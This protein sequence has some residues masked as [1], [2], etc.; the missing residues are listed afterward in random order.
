MRKCLTKFSRFFEFGAVQKPDNLWNDL[1][2]SFQ[3]SIQ[4]YSLGKIGV[5]TAE[6]RPRK[7]LKTGKKAPMIR[8]F[9]RCCA[10]EVL[11]MSESSNRWYFVVL[12]RMFL[13]RKRDRSVN[14]KRDRSLS[15][16]SRYAR[17]RNLHLKFAKLDHSA[18]GCRSIYQSSI[19][20]IWE[21][22]YTISQSIRRSVLHRQEKET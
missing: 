1:F 17:R 9:R 3:T 13:R 14:K 12:F 21:A 10:V 22:M 7:G 19:H 15:P 4:Y 16:R 5:D 6:N 18:F 2:K 20:L 11:K 8:R